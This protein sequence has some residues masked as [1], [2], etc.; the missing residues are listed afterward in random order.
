[1]QKGQTATVTTSALEPEAHDY[2]PAV[3]V[4][5]KL[6]DPGQPDSFCDINLATEEKLWTS[7]KNSTKKKL[8]SWIC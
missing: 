3:C 5:F 1:M 2:N 6:A 8:A 4:D 7:G